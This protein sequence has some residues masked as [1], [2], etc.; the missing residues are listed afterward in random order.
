MFGIVKKVIGSK[1]DRELKKLNPLIQQINQLESE[2][3]KLTDEQLRAKTDIFRQQLQEGKSLDDLLPEAFAVVREASV[4]TLKMRHFD[5]QL[6]GGIV[7]HQGKIAEMKTGEGKTL[8]ATMPIYLNALEGKSAHVITVNDYLARRDADWMGTIYRFLGLS[9]GVILHGMDD[10]E[11]QEAYGCDVTYGTNNEFGF[12]YLRDNMKF[13]LED[14]A[15]RE[16]NFAIVD[17]VDS[18]L[19]DEARTPLIISGPTEDRTDKYYLIDK[20]IPRLNK[21]TDYEIEEKT[22]TVVLSDQGV[23]RIEEL[24]KINNLFEPSQMETLHHVNQALKAHVLFKRD[25][26]YVVKDNQVMIVDEF[27]GRLMPGRR[28]SDGLHQALEA[29]EGVKIESENQTLASVTFQNFFRMYNKLA[30]MTGTADTE[31]VEFK[32]IYNLDVMVVPTNMP[33]IRIDNPDVIYK[34]K[35]EKYRAVVREIIE[36]HQKGQPMLVGTISIDD[37]EKLSRMLTKKGVRHEVLNAKF[38]EKEAEIVAQAGRKGALTIAT[39]MAG[40][41]TDIV[42]G[43]NVEMLAKKKIKEDM[44]AEE[45]ERILNELQAQCQGER[46][47]VLAAG[48]L[49]ILG[50]ER[51]ES[52]RIDNQLRGR[53]GRQGDPGSTRFYLA[54]DDDLMRI[55]GSERIAKVMDTLGIEEDEPIE[56][57]MIS[58][59]IENA[60]R[61]V[62]GHNFD[63][64][65]QLLEYDDVM[66]KQRET[67]YAL[68]RDILGQNNLRELALDYVDEVA[69]ELIERLVAE[70]EPLPEWDYEALNA[71]FSQDFGLTVDFADDPAVQ[72]VSSRES[73]IELFLQRLHHHYEQRE[74]E[75]GVETMRQLEKI[76]LLHTLD[77]LWKEHLYSIDQ[78]KEGIGLRGYGQKDPLREYQREGY[79]MFIDMLVRVKE[80]AVIQLCHIRVT[81][82][83]EV[84]ELDRQSKK[85]TGMVLG[86]GEGVSESGKRQPVRN[87]EAKVGRNDPCPCGSG[88]KYKRCCGR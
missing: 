27:T 73:F 85:Q 25:V 70:K 2:I 9:V 86:R 21:E 74:Q 32:Q 81:R 43:G 1:N 14:Y 20:V 6:M 37:S 11:R 72:E 18:I 45:Q 10:Q 44:P 64:R 7:L 80:D 35:T 57:G 40:R 29:K 75:I 15:Q 4:R 24:L 38:H 71:G 76:V 82:D 30:G 13:Q 78:L 33:M 83:E 31:A 42:L 19:V 69:T 67:I 39:N 56:H 66:N 55:F 52:R 88:K 53:S 3:K 49:H 79:D 65:K 50:T 12:D 58:K 77:T 68:R 51:H 16:L 48:G 61:R 28:Y 47:E 26:D 34:T 23:A 62:E 22:K 36:R 54:L 87:K 17:E 63:I 5:V 84:E 8:M 59:A 46:E 41:G 60:Q